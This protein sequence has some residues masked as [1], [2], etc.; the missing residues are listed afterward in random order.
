MLLFTLIRTGHFDYEN[1]KKSLERF[2]VHRITSSIQLN[3]P[4]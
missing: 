2:T 1:N 3:K 4:I